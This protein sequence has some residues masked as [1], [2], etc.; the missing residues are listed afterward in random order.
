VAAAVV[1]RLYH[2]SAHFG[3]RVWFPQVHELAFLE[4]LLFIASCMV[5][6]K[7]CKIRAGG[8]LVPLI[9]GSLL[10]LSGGLTL[11]LPQ[12]F[13][14][15]SYTLLGWSIGLR[16]T[17]QIL[18]HA[19]RTLPQTMFSVLLLM[20]FCW[21][22]AGALVKLAGVDPLTAYLAT[23]PGGMDAAA[24]IASSCKVDMPFVVSMQAARLFLVL[25]LGPV[26]SRWVAAR[27]AGGPAE[28]AR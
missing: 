16:F 1:A 3:S 5:L 20:A 12:W 22:L 9:L 26:L 25:L 17:R 18:G 28:A 21:A 4:T 24:I 10:N 27:V 8:I 23:S 13:L 15:L 2:A 19:F 7:L 14:A 6:G 11:E